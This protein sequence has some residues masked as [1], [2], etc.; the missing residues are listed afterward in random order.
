MSDGVII[1][2]VVMM[3]RNLVATTRVETKSNRDSTGNDEK[4]VH[5][6]NKHENYRCIEATNLMRRSDLKMSTNSNRPAPVTTSCLANN[7][8]KKRVVNS[9][10]K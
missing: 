4:F 7:N 3:V 6:T 1:A 5:G 10:F 9:I 8:T 2:M